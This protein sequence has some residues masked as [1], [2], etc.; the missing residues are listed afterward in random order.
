MF[1]EVDDFIEKY[2]RDHDPD[3]VYEALCLWIECFKTCESD[4]VK[5]LKSIGADLTDDLVEKMTSHIFNSFNIDV[6][7]YRFQVLVNML[8]PENPRSGEQKKNKFKKK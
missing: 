8:I 6:T 2:F 5:Q 3:K 1:K 7:N 4:R